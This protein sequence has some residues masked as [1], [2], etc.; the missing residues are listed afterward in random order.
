MQPHCLRGTD[1]VINDEETVNNIIASTSKIVGSENIVHLKSLLG[2]EDFSFYRKY[3]E[4]IAFY[5]VGT[6]TPENGPVIQLHNAHY[7][8]NDE[9]IPYCIAAHIQCVYDLN[10]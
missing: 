9:V 7:D 1:A 6:G 8:T 10:G 3:V 4:K 5:R 2:G